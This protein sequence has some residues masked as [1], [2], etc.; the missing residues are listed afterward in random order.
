VR[1]DADV[2]ANVVVLA[3]VLAATPELR[4]LPSGDELCV[5]RVTV[6]RPPGDRVRVDSI[7]CVARTA[8]ARRAVLRAA[9]GDPVEVTGSLHRRFWRVGAAVASRY[10]VQARSVTRRRSSGRQTGG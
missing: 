6:R 2:D 7:D 5:F 9:P 8:A 10:E 3:G 1:V 4:T